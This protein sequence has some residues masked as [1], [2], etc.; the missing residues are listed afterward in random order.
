MLSLLALSC[1]VPAVPAYAADQIV[2]STND[3]GAGSLRRA[4]ADVGAG[5]TITFNLTY[6]AT[7][8]LT[9][10][11]LTIDKNLTITGPGAD[12]LTISG[13][14]ASRVLQIESSSTLSISGLTIT[15]AE[16]SVGDGG[17]AV[18]SS[19]TFNASDCVFSNNFAYEG[20][21]AIRNDSGGTLHLS[22]CTFSDNDSSDGAGAVGNS[23]VATIETCA[24]SNSDGPFGGAVYNN[25]TITII[26]SAFTNNSAGSL[27]GGLANAGT[28]TISSCTFCGN[29]AGAGSGA[30]HNFPDE[31]VTLRNCTFSGNSAT[32]AGGALANL[33]TASISNCTFLGNFVAASGVGGAIANYDTLNIKNS[34]VGSCPEGDCCSS[35]GPWN[36]FGVGFD[37]DGTCAGFTQ[38]TPAQLN[39]GPL[40]DNGG[41]TRTHALLSGSAAIDA[42]TDCTDLAGAAVTTDQRGLARP[43]GEH[44]DV[45]AYEFRGPPA[46]S[47][48]FRVASIGDTFADGTFAATAF[49]VSGAD[50]AEWVQVIGLVEVGDVVM[51]DPAQPGAY[52]LADGPCWT[53]VAGVVVAQP[54]IALGSGLDAGDRALL[55]LVGIVPVKVT[56]EGGPIRPGALLVTSSTPGHAMRW[57]GDEPCPCALVGKALE[58]MTDESGMILVLLTAH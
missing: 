6:P 12:Q 52:T 42:A 25:G 32:S 20:G 1:L 49:E 37:T 4:I 35:S 46:T 39:L 17:G 58:P 7:I 51:L 14:S 13:N 53:R 3:S 36:A 2:T 38:K 54:G 10:G 47:A 57:D 45:G 5:G 26:S 30:L 19:G 8:I 40:A 16:V 27:G 29:E 22:N 55:A 23:G 11:C 18:D 56:D 43:F 48:A 31:S 28:A 44:C 34:I 24:F 33:G 50:I 15:D 41:A 21:G 9:S